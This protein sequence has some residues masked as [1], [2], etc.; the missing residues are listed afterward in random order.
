MTKGTFK[1]TV[2]DT[3]NG[4]ELEKLVD[5]WKKVKQL[6]LDYVEIGSL[7]T[8]GVDE[9]YFMSK[10]KKLAFDIKVLHNKRYV[11]LIDMDLHCL[12]HYN[13]YADAYCY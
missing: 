2:F 5:T 9:S 8:S 6:M 13:E 11:A 4:V 1:V 3:E 12:L 10:C 7:K